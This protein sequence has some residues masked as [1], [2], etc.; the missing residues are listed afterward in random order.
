[1]LVKIQPSAA[2]LAAGALSPEHVAAAKDAIHRDGV[3]VL[4]GVVAVEHVVALREKLLADLELILQRDDVPFNFNAGNVQQDPPPTAPW[5]FEDV[6]FNPFVGQVTKAALGD[7]PKLGMYSG[8]TAL[9]GGK[10]RQPVH[11]DIG[12]MWPHMPEATPP[13]GLVI[14]VPVMH[15]DAHNGVTEIWPG[16]HQDTSVAISDGEI[17]LDET[18]LEAARA[19]GWGPVQPTLEE[20]DALIRDIRMWHAG[21]PNHSDV[22]R[23]LV[24]LIHYVPWFGY[25]G[26]LRVPRQSEA[27]FRDRDVWV[28][29]DVVDGEVDHIGAN[30]AYDFQPAER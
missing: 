24:A 13:Y 6:L 30:T 16:T 25:A 26:K 21:M 4:Q 14:N 5:L 29:L 8:N 10:P 17:K 19:K 2:E 18:R 9:P 23:P 28:D 12:H 11:A 15:T 22:A 1:M 3:V 20:G 7:T 27:F